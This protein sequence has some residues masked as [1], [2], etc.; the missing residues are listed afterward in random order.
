[1]QLN[2]VIN[3]LNWSNTQKP[4]N[5][6]NSCQVWKVE[7]C[8]WLRV[9][10]IN[11]TSDEALCL[12]FKGLKDRLMWLCSSMLSHLLCTCCDRPRPLPSSPSVW[13]LIGRHS[14]LHRPAVLSSP[15][16]SYRSTVSI[17]SAVLFFS[18]FS[19]LGGQNKNTKQ[20]RGNV[21][22]IVW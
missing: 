7:M 11:R 18:F 21:I 10:R 3:A 20:K 19:V 15:L 8:S 12:W 13:F 6:K 4:L 1:M 14:S 22:I 2:C 9:C 16:L 17:T 5:T